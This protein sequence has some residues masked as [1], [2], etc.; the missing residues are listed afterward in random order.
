MDRS[1]V[2]QWIDGFK[3]GDPDAAAKIWRRYGGALLSLA[4]RKLRNTRKRVSDEEDVAM[5]AFEHFCRGVQEGRFS[6]LE[7]RDDLWQLLVMLINRR[8]FDQMRRE[9]RRN[10]RG[11][12]VFLKSP[13]T[14]PERQLPGTIPD[15]AL[16][17]HV[18]VQAIEECSRF[19]EVLQ[20]GTLQQIACW[21]MEG[22]TN[23]EIADKLNV[24]TRTV[25][26]KLNLIRK[27]W[28]EMIGSD[29]QTSC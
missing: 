4:R 6:Q 1:S 9:I 16:P 2:T 26:R 29:E 3:E 5:I 27:K 22:H 10:E 7:D 23:D 17:P 14:T 20:D 25:E 12:S 18:A 11:E 28:T 15:M 24:V 21:K 8:S 13:T 19:L